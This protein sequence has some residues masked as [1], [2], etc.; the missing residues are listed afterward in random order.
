VPDVV[1]FPGEDEEDEEDIM[2][3]VFRLVD[4]RTWAL[5]CE[6]SEG[7]LVPEV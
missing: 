6:G 4:S 7:E 5:L 2:A 3:V 1:V